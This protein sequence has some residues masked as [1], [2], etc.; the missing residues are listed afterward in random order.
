MIIPAQPPR[1]P[2]KVYTATLTVATGTPQSR[3]VASLDPT[4]YTYRPN[5][6]RLRSTAT[7]TVRRSAD[8]NPGLNTH[9]FTWTRARSSTQPG[10]ASRGNGMSRRPDSQM[11]APRATLNMPSV[12]TKGGRRRR[13]MTNPLINPHNPPA[14]TPATTAAQLAATI[15]DD[16]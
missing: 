3:A 12:A 9:G 10:W 7:I 1:S 14:A 5:T 15:P 16:W 4:A 11:A 2:A 8:Q 13:V 6:V